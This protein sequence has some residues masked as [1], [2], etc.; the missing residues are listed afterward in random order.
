MYMKQKFVC[1]ETYSQC[2]LG[3]YDHRA[4]FYDHNRKWRLKD[5]Y[6][7]AVGLLG[8]LLEM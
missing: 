2:P 1:H 7:L 8:W 3:Y 6:E 4:E 5:G